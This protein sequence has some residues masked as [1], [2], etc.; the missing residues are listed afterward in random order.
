MKKRNWLI[1]VVGLL[2]AGL[3]SGCGDNSSPNPTSA[4]VSSTSA[5]VAT[6]EIA[7]T[8]TQPVATKEVATTAI[9]KVATTAAPATT[10][11]AAKTTTAAVPDGAPANSDTILLRF[12]E[13]YAPETSA[14]NLVLSDKLKGANN[15]RVKITGYM[16]PP[17]KPDLDF[18]V[19]TRIRLATC[20][21]CSTA[22]D[23][24]EDIILVTMP[25]GK[26]IRQVEEPI[27]LIGKLEVGEGVDTK[28]G[29]F[30]LLRIRA[31]NYEIFK[32]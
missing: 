7:A 25:E 23:W 4:S 32:G 6:K 10:A 11:I 26:T 5:A 28:T 31:E 30:S 20:P 3:V 14:I 22:A 16:A 12:N 8:T 17:L 29:F 2:V 15:K 19:L 13:F 9:S 18:F 1:V 27:T 21:F 24:P